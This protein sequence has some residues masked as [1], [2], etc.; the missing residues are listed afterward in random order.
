[1]RGGVE[2]PAVEHD[3]VRAQSPVHRDEQL[4]ERLPFVVRWRPHGAAG[5]A[6]Y[7]VGV[8][9]GDHVRFRADAG[10][11]D[12][13]VGR[14]FAEAGEVGVVV[15][16]FQGAVLGF[17]GVALDGDLGDGFGD[18]DGLV[19]VGDDVGGVEA[20]QRLPRPIGHGEPR[21]VVDADACGRAER[22]VVESARVMVGVF[23]PYRP[24][25]GVRVEA[26][27]QSELRWVVVGPVGCHGCGGVEA[28]GVGLWRVR[29][30]GSSV[31]L[32]QSFGHGADPMQARVACI[33]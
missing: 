9:G 10:L 15:V 7:A 21:R 17:R 25:S 29:F 13:Q 4:R 2:F 11:R 6:P 16:E 33:G 30:P 20:V 19:V 22:H 18:D 8:V 1:M 24:H 3:G 26:V 28:V 27:E 23:I 5:S 12:G 14:Q 31:E 32:R